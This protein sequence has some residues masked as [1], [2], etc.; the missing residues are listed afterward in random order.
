MKQGNVSKQRLLALPEGWTGFL[1]RGKAPVKATAVN[2]G[3]TRIPWRMLD[4]GLFLFFV[5]FLCLC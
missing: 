4:W 2:E 1:L 5:W 3:S